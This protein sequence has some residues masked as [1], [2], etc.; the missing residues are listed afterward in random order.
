MTPISP[1]FAQIQ[2]CSKSYVAAENPRQNC[3]TCFKVETGHWVIG[4]AVKAKT[5]YTPSAENHGLS[6]KKWVGRWTAVPQD[7]PSTPCTGLVEVPILDFTIPIKT[8]SV[9]QQLN[10]NHRVLKTRQKCANKPFICTDKPFICVHMSYC[11]CR[12]HVTDYY[13]LP[14]FTGF[15]F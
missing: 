14:E 8:R 7:P 3:W 12:V 13:D 9:N 2:N 15:K 1:S 11:C 6:P 5:R 10:F 4:M